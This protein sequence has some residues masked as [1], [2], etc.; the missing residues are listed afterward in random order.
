VSRSSVNIYLTVSLLMFTC[1]AIL[2]PTI[3]THNLTNFCNV[4]FSY[5]RCWLTRSLFIIDALPSEK[6]VTHMQM[7]FAS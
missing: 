6:C 1:S 4:F 7:V 5:A 2:L 3:F